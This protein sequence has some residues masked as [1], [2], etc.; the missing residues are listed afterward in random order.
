MGV[1]FFFFWVFCFHILFYSAVYAVSIVLLL[2]C[3]NVKSTICF[4]RMAS[5]VL[6]LFP[7]YTASRTQSLWKAMSPPPNW[8][9]GAVY[10]LLCCVMQ[11]ISSYQVLNFFSFNR[12]NKSADV[13]NCPAL[14]MALQRTS[15]RLLIW[16]EWSGSVDSPPECK[17]WLSCMWTYYTNDQSLI[18]TVPKGQSRPKVLHSSVIYWQRCTNY[19]FEFINEW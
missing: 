12:S 1:F 18:I 4:I 13:S 6:C 5:V 3:P 15:Q 9:M 17:A 7:S 19:N 2:L 10:T 8:M 11:I 14:N 16:V